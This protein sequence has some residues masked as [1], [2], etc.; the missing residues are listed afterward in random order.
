MTI[1]D[2]DDYK[3][4]LKK[5]L[6]E[7]KANISKRFT[8]QKMADACVV[9]K[10][11]LSRVLN[12]DAHLNQDQLFAACSFLG[13]SSEQKRFVSLLHARQR[14][15]LKNLQDDLS[16]QI[17]ATRSRNRK[18][19]S[20]ITAQSM[21]LDS[22][23]INQ[24]FLDP[25]A[26]LVHMF[27]TTSKYAGDLEAIGRCLGLSMD[28]LIE[29][30]NRLQA[31]KLIELESGKYVVRQRDFHLS[32]ESPLFRAYRLGVRVRA[33]EKL[34]NSRSKDNYSFS[35][36]FSSNEET[37]A[38]IHAE[39]LKYLQRVEKWVKDGKEEEVYQMNF[40]LMNWSAQM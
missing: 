15:S 35:V 6:L 12:N 11:Y 21:N 3:E 22:E 14:S 28:T 26:Q 13:F 8:F 31:L 10:A 19:D 9:E 16:E 40:D 27:F 33:Y 30:L 39:F 38:K 24:Y 36:I 18:T 34:Q 37:R 7:K 5:F 29:I 23:A 4:V 25:N 32:A 2:F 17:R 20:H 1:Y